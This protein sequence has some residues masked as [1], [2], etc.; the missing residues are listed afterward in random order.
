MV[1]SNMINFSSNITLKQA[2]IPLKDLTKG[3]ERFFQLDTLREIATS[4]C[5]ETLYSASAIQ[6]R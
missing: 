6:L 1:L 4:T 2:K 3:C 5:G